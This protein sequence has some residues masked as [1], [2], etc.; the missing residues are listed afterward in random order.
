MP[1]AAA[2]PCLAGATPD[3][4]SAAFDATENTPSHDAGEGER[5]KYLVTGTAGF[6]GFHLARR[7]LAEGHAVVGIDGMTPY[8]D[9]R[10]KQRRQ[11]TL[12]QN[13]HFAAHEFMLE[14]NARLAAVLEAERPDVIVHLAAQAGV[15]YSIENPRAYIEANV[16]GTFNLLEQARALKTPHLMLASTS[17]VYGASENMPFQEETPTDQPLTLYAATKKAT[18]VMS[19]SYAHLFGI[20]TT[21]FRF[22]SVYGPWGRPDMALFKFTEN[23]L[24]GLPIDIYNHGVMERDFTYVDDLVEAIARLSHVPPA[25]PGSPSDDSAPTR[26]SPVAPYRL[27]NIG[28]GQPVSLLTFIEEIEK[29]IG[30]KAIPNMMPMQPGDV[31]KTWADT[32]LLQALTGFKPSTPVAKGVKA[33]V[34]WYREYYGV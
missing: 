20:P 11:S 15:R 8:Y 7:L 31:P 24:K 12:L 32:S 23:I 16:V 29:A 1:E 14:D 10:L 27:V 3:A 18:E 13:P 26:S 2:T 34:D 9:V 6:I 4:T 25:A 19:H 17:S 28:N 21:A 30:R 5:L 22:F 33:F